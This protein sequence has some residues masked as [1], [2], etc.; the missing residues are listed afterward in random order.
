[1]ADTARLIS[2]LD[3][4]A[5]SARK[6]S[7]LRPFK[8]KLGQRNVAPCSILVNGD[9][10]GEGARA[11][12]T[13]WPRVLR[14]QM[15]RRLGQNA[16]GGFGYVPAWYSTG[17]QQTPSPSQF[18]STISH[19]GSG[20][21]RGTYGFG[22]RCLAMN[23]GDVSTLTIPATGPYKST[24]VDVMWAKASTAAT[25][26]V[27]KLNGAQVYTTTTNS[28][29]PAGAQTYRVAIP[30]DGAQHVITVEVTGQ[31]LYFEGWFLYN[32][33]ESTG[34]RVIDGC[35]SGST[36]GY[37]SFTSASAGGDQNYM[38]DDVA[39]ASPALIVWITGINNF[40]NSSA[41]LSTPAEYLAQ[42]QA[43]HD[44]HNARLGSAACPHVIIK[45]YERGPV[46]STA[47]LANQCAA[48]T[49]AID[50]FVAA[51]TDVLLYDMQGRLPAGPQTT[52]LGL[53]HTDL[54]HLTD[55]GGTFFGDDFTSFLIAA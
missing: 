20:Q 1:M 45:Q 11:P 28:G 22:R 43:A 27:I 23:P 18:S 2:P 4:E 42:L 52:A 29:A 9:S 8:A 5:M 38:L 24:N 16:A 14:D 35:S 32:G 44:N 51:N 7:I 54:T 19:T 46:G 37:F 10:T 21:A 34:I 3:A 36:A 55:V 25:S 50:Q 30:Q 48:Y 49:A 41:Q 12:N 13:P 53:V 31:V 15:R 40:Y 39:W 47:G 6:A 33:D 26:I 17:D